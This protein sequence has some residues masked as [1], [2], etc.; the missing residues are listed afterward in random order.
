[1]LFIPLSAESIDFHKIKHDL[2]RSLL[3]HQ[4]RLWIWAADVTKCVIKY[5]IFNAV[6]VLLTPLNRFL[7]IANDVQ[8]RSKVS[9]GKGFYLLKT[10]KNPYFLSFV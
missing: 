10:V 2:A 3:S 9:A 7:H 1:M 4:M 8:V 5:G 6:L